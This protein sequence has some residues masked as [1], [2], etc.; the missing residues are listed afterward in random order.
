MSSLR[1]VAD[2]F[3]DAALWAFIS[4]LL[5]FG[6]GLAGGYGFIISAAGTAMYFFNTWGRLRKAMTDLSTI[7]V[8]TGN[9]VKGTDYVFYSF[10]GIALG[11]LIGFLGMLLFFIRSIQFVSV[12]AALGTLGAII[13]VVSVILYLLGSIPIGMAVYNFGLNYNSDLMRIA[14]ILIIIPG[15]SIIG[16]LMAYVEVDNIATGGG[17]RFQ[18]PPPPQPVPSATQVSP[19][20]VGTLNRTGEAVVTLNSNAYLQIVNAF[21][22]GYSGVTFVS[23][24]PNTLNLGRNVVTIR[25][26]NLPP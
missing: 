24:L 25:F 2:S 23:A 5:V 10:A 15:L 16:W 14:G 19:E 12:V 22:Q 9:A 18:P 21:L 7:G 3:K 20:G 8:Q 1:P 4:N 11:G 26:S 17:M 13:S 6:A